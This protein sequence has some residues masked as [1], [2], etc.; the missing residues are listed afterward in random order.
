MPPRGSA[1]RSPTSWRAAAG[2][3][4]ST[5]GT[6]AALTEAVRRCRAARTRR[7]PATSPTRRTAATWSTWPP[8]WAAPDA[9][10]NNASTLGTSPLP[11]FADLDTATYLHILQVNLVAP[12]ALT[13]ALLPQLRAARRRG[14]EP[15]VGRVGRGLRDLGRLRLVQGRRSTTRPGCWPPRS[16]RC[17]CTPSTRA[18]CGPR[19]TRTRS[20]ARTSPTGRSRRSPYRRCSG[21]WRATLPSGR[22]RAAELLADDGQSWRPHERRRHRGEV[23]AAA[24]QRGDRAAR[25]PGPGPRRGPDG[26]GHRTSGPTTGRRASS[27]VAGARRPARRQH[28]RDA[29]VRAG[30]ASGTAARGGC[31]SRREL[32]DGAW[33]V[34]LRRPDGAGPGLSRARRGAA[35]AGRRT[36]AH[37]GAAPGR[38]DPAL[39]GDDPAHRRPGGATCGGTGRRSATPTCT[40]CGRSRTCRTCTPQ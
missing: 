24:R 5:P 9:L 28:Q 34:E 15:V 25:G 10:V 14:P 4:S 37:R 27:R 38:P 35:A 13:A 11:T 20:P 1:A 8:S 29:A 18:T 16:P 12:M 7:S 36:A 17:G 2:P 19:C 33:V 3:W 40:A 22:Y 30:R 31:T 23:R 39:A 6:G 32:D 26:R 21:S